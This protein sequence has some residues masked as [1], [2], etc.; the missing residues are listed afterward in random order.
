VQRHSVIGEIFGYLVC[1]LTI[2]IFFMSVAGIVN[3][4]FRVANPT[5]G[6]QII[7]A[8]RLLGPPGRGGNFFYRTFGRRGG[9][10]KVEG[11]LPGAMPMPMPSGAPDVTTMRA[12][13]VGDARFDAVRRL[14]LA[15]VMLVLSILVF[16][17]TFEW[18]NAKQATG[19]GT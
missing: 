9:P 2:V 11:P 13:F 4:A 15:I 8:A 17:R 1:L 19:G 6:P 18:L 12:N 14:V 3:S 7:G 5:A 16:R 10:G